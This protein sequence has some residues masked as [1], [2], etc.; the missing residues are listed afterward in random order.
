MPLLWSVFSER[1]LIEHRIINGYGDDSGI[2]S[3]SDGCRP[4]NRLL[5]RP[6]LNLFPTDKLHHHTCS[7]VD[8][9]FVTSITADTNYRVPINIYSWK[10]KCCAV[11]DVK[12]AR[13]KYRRIASNIG[14]SDDGLCYYRCSMATYRKNKTS[15]GMVNIESRV[16]INVTSV[17]IVVSFPY[18]R[19][20]MVP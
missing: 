11:M 13:G 20:S 17:I 4:A 6:I 9:L 15:K 18:F 14:P 10:R 7:H 1:Y 3:C 12:V 5:L 16:V 8:S 2:Y 19:Q